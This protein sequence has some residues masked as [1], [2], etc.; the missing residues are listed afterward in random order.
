VHYLLDEL[1]RLLK[2]H[3]AVTVVNLLQWLTMRWKNSVFPIGIFSQRSILRVAAVDR[4]RKKR[5]TVSRNDWRLNLR[6]DK[7]SPIGIWATQTER[8]NTRPTASSSSSYSRVSQPISFVSGGLKSGSKIEKPQQQGKPKTTGSQKKPIPIESYDSDEDSDEKLDG[9]F[10]DD[11][12]DVKIIEKKGKKRRDSSDEMD[13]D[14]EDEQEEED[15]RRAKSVRIGGKSEAKKFVK[16]SQS[17]EEIE[18]PIIQRQPPNIQY[19][20]PPPMKATPVRDK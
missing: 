1:S 12:D 13:S 3:I 18:P 20:R 14:N 16:L 2:L 11:D 7:S 10:D 4:A 19:Q 8:A 6:K 9:D 15:H 5:P 17:D